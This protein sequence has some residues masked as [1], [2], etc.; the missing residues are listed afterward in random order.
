MELVGQVIDGRYKVLSRLGEGGMGTVYRATQFSVNRAVALKVIRPEFAGGEASIKR[1]LR[2][3]TAT[4]GLR[5]PNT[6][7]VYDSGQTDDGLLYI[8]MELVTGRTLKEV[9]DEEGAQPVPRSL[10]LLRQVCNS[11]MEAHAEG[12]IH[13]DL[14]P[15]NLMI[16]DRVGSPDFLTVLDFGIARIGSNAGAESLTGTGLMVGSPAYMS[17]EQIQSSE[18]D[19]RSD[20]YALGVIG[21]EI[22]CG[23]PPFVDASYTSLFRRHC[24]E[25]PLSIRLAHPEIAIPEELD[26]LVL[27]CLAK[28][29]DDRPQSARELREALDGLRDHVVDTSSRIGLEPTR[30]EGP[31]QPKLPQLETMTVSAVSLNKVTPDLAE[32][33]DAG[34]KEA[35]AILAQ[36]GTGEPSKG[37]PD[38]QLPGRSGNRVLVATILVLMLVGALIIAV[39]PWGIFTFH[40]PHGGGPTFL[41]PNPLIAV[42]PIKSNPE[43]VVDRMLWP[44]A[45]RMVVNSFL[46]SR[47]AHPRFRL[48]DPLDVEAEMR[49]REMVPPIST[50]E[51]L[52]LARALDADV[53]VNGE[54]VRREGLMH[55]DSKWIQ[56]DNESAGRIEAHGADVFEAS[57]AFVQELISIL[58]FQDSPDPGREKTVPLTNRVRRAWED[59]LR[60][61]WSEHRYTEFQAA[62]ADQAVGPLAEFSRALAGDRAVTNACSQTAATIGARFPDEMGLLAPAICHFRRVELEDALHCAEQAAQALEFRELAYCFITKFRTQAQT[63]QDRAEFLERRIRLFPDTVLAWWLLAL[64]YAA[65]DRSE[66]LKEVL[67][68][69]EYLSGRKET[70]FEALLGAVRYYMQIGNFDKARTW[71]EPLERAKAED[72]WGILYRAG[73]KASLLQLGGRFS[74]AWDV[75]EKARRVLRDPPGDQYT[76]AATGLVYSYLTFGM[77]EEAAQIVDEYQSFF[78]G[79]EKPD[80]WTGK[81][82]EVALAAARTEM[83]EERLL[84]EAERNGEAIIKL[85]PK[86][87]TERDGFVCQLLAHFAPAD[88]VHDFLREADPEGTMTGCCKIRA[89]QALFAKGRHREARDLFAKAR[90]DLI[91]RSDWCLELYPS[92]LLGEARSAEA[93]GDEIGALALYRTLL[94]QYRD[95]DRDLQEVRVA[96]EAVSRLSSGGE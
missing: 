95:A 4:G 72:S 54:L 23:H 65:L 90:R 22:L 84:A 6:I 78:E 10:Q 79:T 11:L 49:V 82:L 39:D 27:R 75:W 56:L 9:L 40:D 83:A 71:M 19:H 16:E 47:D 77:L 18:V 80:V 73:R 34:S 96:G 67:V 1:F 63:P 93:Q 88:R 81:L 85:L 41:P 8:T 5:S 53:V 74:E 37:K 33:L 2:E 70:N 76:I 29:P 36:V 86:A 51:A 3:S 87:G 42:L 55:F 68:T 13:R 69:A 38:L 66:E 31:A 52:E 26:H 35:Q 7:T 61:P 43:R 17:P 60:D 50:P 45:D 30:P 57:D 12:I 32:T 94:S 24:L 28:R 25:T 62:T 14:K 15:A 20:I 92:A 44:L 64:E 46:R 91:Y 58:P 21:Y 89:A 59:L 48:V